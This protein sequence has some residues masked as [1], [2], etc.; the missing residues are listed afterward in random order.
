[1]FQQGC[2]NEEGLPGRG[3]TYARSYDLKF[4]HVRANKEKSTDISQELCTS[5]YDGY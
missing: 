5:S 1:M 3:N 2:E 4:T